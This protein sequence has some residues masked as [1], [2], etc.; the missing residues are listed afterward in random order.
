MSG[1][2]EKRAGLRP[3]LPQWK[4]AGVGVRKR[5]GSQMGWGLGLLWWV[6]GAQG[7]DG[8][9]EKVMG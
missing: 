6:E 2:G 4:K 8:L 7:Q 5:E 3:P 1:T 9:R